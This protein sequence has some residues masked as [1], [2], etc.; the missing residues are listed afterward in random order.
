MN[1][2]KKASWR[3]PQ[4]ADVI[5][6]SGPETYS[7]GEAIRGIKQ[8]IREKHSLFEISEI[9]ASEYVSGQLLNL[10]S[11][12]LFAEPRLILI[13]NC[14]RCTDAF[15]EDG[16]NYLSSPADETTVVIHHNGSSV[17]GKALLEAIKASSNAT[18]ILCPKITKDSDRAAFVRQIFTD[19]SRTITDGA[20]RALTQAFSQDVPELAAA[21]SQLLADSSETITEEI[22]DR[23]YG[24]RVEVD[25]FKIIDAALT[26][27]A[28]DALF[29]LRHAFAS[30][31]DL[32]LM[33]A[34]FNSRI[35][36]MAKVYANPRANAAAL[37]LS[38]WVAS[39]ARTSIAGWDDDGLGRVIQA[40]A[41]AD[42][43]AKGAE[44]DPQFRLE[45]L[46][47]LIARKGRP[48]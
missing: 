3:N 18:E 25:A 33:V 40:L 2:S 47:A 37:G 8:K 34:G 12:S 36:S 29:M 23:Y 43:A 48:L 10:A 7:V 19:S 4:L 31:L 15:I 32:V 21:A 17:R 35:R 30:G 42:A 24:G 13:S 20:I 28:A 14:D 41:D 38:D 22:V 1:P 39:Q 6:V 16:K 45:Q 9:D 11:P 27:R 5:L 46:I 26:G 44:R